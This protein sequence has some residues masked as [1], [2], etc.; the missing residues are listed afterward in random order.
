[1]DR[2]AQNTATAVLGNLDAEVSLQSFKTKRNKRLGTRKA[3]AVRREVIK[4]YGR[5]SRQERVILV[6]TIPLLKDV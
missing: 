5:D 2:K 1:M 6:K 4:N 3:K